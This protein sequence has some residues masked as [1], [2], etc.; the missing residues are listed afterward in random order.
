ME[1][2]L[3]EVATRSMNGTANATRVVDM[4]LKLS[5]LWAFAVLN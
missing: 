4:R 2:Q 3:S 5:I 1:E